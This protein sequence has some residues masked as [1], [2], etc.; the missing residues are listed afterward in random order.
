MAGNL[1]VVVAVALAVAALLL[2][3]QFVYWALQARAERQASELSRRLGTVSDKEEMG[4]ALLRAAAPV[5]TRSFGARLDSLLRQAGSPY[6]LGAIATPPRSSARSARRA[7]WS[8]PW[9]RS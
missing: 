5:E 2:F 7:P 1:V 3:G 6:S 4:N 8:S 9:C